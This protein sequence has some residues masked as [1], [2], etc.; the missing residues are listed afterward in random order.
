MTKPCMLKLRPFSLLLLLVMYVPA[1]A[2]VDTSIG[3]IEDKFGTDYLALASA[4]CLDQHGEKEKANAIYNWVTHNI[5]YD[6]QFLTKPKHYDDKVAHAL[7]T[8]KAICEG[9]SELFTE[10]CRGAGLKAVNIEGYAKDWIF[11][12]GDQM[13]IPRHEWNAVRINGKWQLVDATWGAGGLYQ[14]RSWLRKVLDKIFRHNKIGAKSLK[15]R[16]KYDPQYFMQDP[17]TFRLKHIPSDPLWQ[18]TDS[19]MPLS[20]FEAGDSATRKFNEL[21]SKPRQSDPRLDKIAELDEKQ[22]LFEF[23]DRAYAYNSRY[24]VILAIKS[25]YRAESVVEKAFTDSTVQNGDIMLKDAT[26]DLKKSLEYIKQQKKTFPEEYNKLKKKNKAKGMEAKQNIRVIKTDDKRLIAECKKH[27]KSGDNKSNR[28][29]KQLSEIQKRK[30]GL[31]PGNIDD[32][33]TAK[34]RKKQGSPELEAIKD[35][36][37]ARNVRIASGRKAAAEQSNK[38]KLAILSSSVLLDSLVKSL[39]QE[40]SM[41]R[42]EAVERLGM[43]DSY[44]DEVKKWG[45]LFRHQKYQ[46]TDTLLKY[47]FAAFDTIVVKYE[48]LGKTHVAVLDL[49]KSNVRSHEQY[50]KWNNT[51]ADLKKDYTD[52]VNDYAQSVDSAARD[53]RVYIAYLEGNKKLF[54]MLSK[55]SKRQLGIV[56]YMEKAEKSRQNLEAGSIARKRAFDVKENESQRAAVQKGL[57]KIQQVVDKIDARK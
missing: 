49:Y 4:L 9:Y 34:V 47:Y 23:A 36:V 45:G 54:G 38:A 18:L 1:K 28:A 3:L 8:K 39:N 56:E 20:V 44:D 37:A 22:K 6:V 30:Q 52:C 12:N 48:A 14:K 31:D 13:Y 24:P 55:Q 10:L 16:P 29:R 50:K 11:D 26:N 40:D 27:T 25:T 15:F 7:K 43:H 57:K 17:E 5:S 51:D 53:I 41:L 46:T 19:A 32:I 21:Y 42:G 33:A 35:S 2:Q